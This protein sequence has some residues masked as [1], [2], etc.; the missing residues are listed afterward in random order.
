MMMVNNPT[1]AYDVEPIKKKKLSNSDRSAKS[2]WCSSC[3]DNQ[4]TKTEHKIGV[5]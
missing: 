2:V 1:I 3:K 4:M 5:T